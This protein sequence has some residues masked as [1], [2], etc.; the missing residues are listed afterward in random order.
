MTE[1]GIDTPTRSG[2][3][4]VRS[5]ERAA[6]TTLGYALSLGIAL[7]LVTIVLVGGGTFVEEQRGDTIRSEL[8][9]IGQQVSSGISRTDQLAQARGTN[10]EIAIEQ[11]IPERVSGSRYTIHVEPS[12]DSKLRLVSESNNVT[13]RV[14]VTTQAD[15]EATS[16]GGGPLVITYDEDTDRL[17]VA[18]D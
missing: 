12:A 5:D 11:N 9:I 8:E 13:V 17:E 2:S 15:L 1:E 4:T 10:S 18:H 3:D 7:T 16:V 14:N 6:A